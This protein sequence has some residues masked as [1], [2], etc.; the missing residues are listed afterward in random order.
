MHIPT[1]RRN[2]GG[3]GDR[4]GRLST[5]NLCPFVGVDLDL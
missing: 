4:Q 3:I 1:Y 5:V 2:L